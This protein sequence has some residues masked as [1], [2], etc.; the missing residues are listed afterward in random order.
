MISVEY[1]HNTTMTRRQIITAILIAVGCSLYLTSRTFRH[2][3][4][5]DE[6]GWTTSSIYHTE[7]LAHAEFSREAWDA[8][9]Y[10]TY[11]WT[12]PQLGKIMLGI[13]LLI[14]CTEHG[15][16]YNGTIY[17][18][19]VDYQTNRRNGAVVPDDILA[20]GRR[21]SAV[22]GGICCGL[23]FALGCMLQGE[24]TG[25]LAALLLLQMPT[26]VF[27]AT[28]VLTDMP[29]NIF[30]IGF[31]LCC[32]VYTRADANPRN[33][34][35]HI[36]MCA[37]LAALATSVKV[38]GLPL[39]CTIFAGTLALELRLGR[40]KLSEAANKLGCFTLYAV[41]LVYLFNPALLPLPTRPA[42]VAGGNHYPD[43]PGFAT[44]SISH[45][46]LFRLP[47]IYLWWSRFMKI[48]ALT[49][50]GWYAPR[51]KLIHRSILYCMGESGQ[52]A[53]VVLLSAV[54]TVMQAVQNWRRK[55]AETS[56]QLALFFIVN[57]LLIL[58]FLRLNWPRYYLPT[59]I[60]CCL[61][62]AFQASRLSRHVLIA[63]RGR[64]TARAN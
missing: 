31:Y 3:Y 24:L 39:C 23:I 27:S 15:R 11:G 56:T 12:N 40:C 35:L 60:A 47:T 57:Y 22:F 32:V 18:Y 46:R 53:M 2:P 64:V 52:L 34:H 25:I 13:P 16:S 17:N 10:D 59:T 6:T 37:L 48:Q 49:S 28:S 44:I 45:N 43:V 1:S 20:V 58:C 5:G 29:Y 50:G 54:A 8:A 36:V 14:Y 42:P 30:L 7:L 19:G 55:H 51:I 63:V 41:V 9:R 4:E 62:V 26:F 33:K 38:Q 21:S 61:M